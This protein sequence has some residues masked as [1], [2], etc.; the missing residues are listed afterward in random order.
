MNGTVWNG[1]TFDGDRRVRMCE[2]G[3]RDGLQVEAAFVPTED[4]IAL[5][6]AL[7]R[8][9]MAKIAVSMPSV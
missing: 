3:L 2:V 5:C 9:G 6:N 4:K 8:A 1:T 7:S